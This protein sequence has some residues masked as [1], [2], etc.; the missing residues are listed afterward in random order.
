MAKKKRFI[1]VHRVFAAKFNS[2][3]LNFDCC[4]SRLPAFKPIRYELREI[5]IP[6]FVV[7]RHGRCRYWSFLIHVYDCA[8]AK[9]VFV[10]FF[11]ISA[12]AQSE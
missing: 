6:D 10:L 4:D 2:F 12:Y 9:S 5:D 3:F 1:I 8:A 11:C 7:L